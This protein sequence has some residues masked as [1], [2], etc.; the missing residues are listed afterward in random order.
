[1]RAVV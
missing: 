1:M